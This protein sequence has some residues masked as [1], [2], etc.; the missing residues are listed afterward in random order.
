MHDRNAELADF[1][2]H[3]GPAGRRRRRRSRGGATGRTAGAFRRPRHRFRSRTQ[4]RISRAA[5][6]AE[7]PACA[8]RPAPR[9][10]RRRRALLHRNRRR[11]P[12]RSGA[13]GGE[14]RGGA[15]Q[16]GRPAKNLRFHHALDRRS[17]PARDRRLDR[18]RFAHSRT[19]AEGAARE[20]DSRRLWAARPSDER[21]SHARRGG[22][23]GSG[24]AP[25]VLGSGARGADRGSGP[26][27]QRKRGRKPSRR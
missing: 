21:L 3:A 7:F 18:R 10:F 5:G 15:D 12:D 4:R 27:R 23:L 25:A 2:R 16:R 1:P 13:G 26:R 22:D 9:G 6:E 20:P 19:H 11:R 8:A 17:Q 24:Y 14:G